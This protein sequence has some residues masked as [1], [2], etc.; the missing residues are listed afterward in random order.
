MNTLARVTLS[1]VLLQSVASAVAWACSCSPDTATPEEH[2]DLHE[3]VFIGEVLDGP[4]SRGCGSSTSSA[5][6]VLYTVEVT[7]SFKGVDLGDKVTLETASDSSSCGL[8]MAVGESRLI[9]SVDDK[10]GSCDPGGLAAE[11]GA[12]IQRLRAATE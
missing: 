9:Y 11:K 3:K 5:D 10:V 7:E 4:R 8:E 12:D 1:F 6:P 2:L